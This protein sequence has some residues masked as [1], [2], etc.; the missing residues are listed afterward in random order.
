MASKRAVDIAA[1]LLGASVVVGAHEGG[2]LD[3]V[4][5]TGNAWGVG[6]E[7]S[8]LGRKIADKM[9]EDAD[10]LLHKYGVEY[11]V[12]NWV[13]ALEAAEAYLASKRVK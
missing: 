7:T 13:E 3:S 10:Q 6:S 9:R 2:D 11:S 5:G 4:P 8:E 1:K 12:Q